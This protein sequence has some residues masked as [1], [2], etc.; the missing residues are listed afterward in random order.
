VQLVLTQ[1]AEAALKRSFGR[2]GIFYDHNLETSRSSKN[3]LGTRMAAFDYAH[4]LF[5][6][7]GGNQNEF[8]TDW[9][10]GARYFVS[11]RASL[12]ASCR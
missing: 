12:C 9:R 11:F 8:Q 10:R 3:I 5:E 4:P 6:S 1:A 7:S 2:A